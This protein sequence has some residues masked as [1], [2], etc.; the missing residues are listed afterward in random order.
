MPSETQ[1]LSMY[2]IGE[3]EGEKI[4][5][6]RA[7]EE[8]TIKRLNAV[9]YIDPAKSGAY[10]QPSPTTDPALQRRLEA[11]RQQEALQTEIL[12]EQQRKEKMKAFVGSITGKESVLT[13]E[14]PAMTGDLRRK[15]QTGKLHASKDDF[16][17]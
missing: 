8:T 14:L 16:L 3:A 9:V 11:R 4:G 2:R 1:L 10:E 5:Y 15:W 7:I 17:L 12:A 6:K 13:G